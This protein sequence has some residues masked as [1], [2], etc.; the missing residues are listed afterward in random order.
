MLTVRPS[1][2]SKL[3]VITFGGSQKLYLDFQLCGVSMSWTPCCSK[4]SCVVTPHPCHTPIWA[5][6]TQLLQTFLC[7]LSLLCSLLDGGSK[8]CLVL[9]LGCQYQFQVL[10][11]GITFDLLC[12]PPHQAY[13]SWFPM[14]AHR[15]LWSGPPTASDER[16][17]PNPPILK[18]ATLR[19]H[20]SF[21]L[22]CCP[23]PASF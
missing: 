1:V 19:V 4:V 20:L 3:W 16:P 18:H 12:P 17:S 22:V 11:F 6:A 2:N 15:Q 5:R 13:W 7:S 21:C 9:C 23:K 10:N 8:T 14:G